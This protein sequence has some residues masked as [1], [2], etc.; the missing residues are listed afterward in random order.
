VPELSP[1]ARAL[2]AKPARQLDLEF[3]IDG[4]GDGKLSL[5]S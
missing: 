2:L 3:S 1:L 5:Y 4:Y